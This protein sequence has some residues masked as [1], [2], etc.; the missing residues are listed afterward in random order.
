MVYLLKFTKNKNRNFMGKQ[1]QVTT[2][3]FENIKSL[4]L[5][6]KDFIFLYSGTVRD[7]YSYHKYLIMVVTDR[8]WH[9]G[10]EIANIPF[11]GQ[12][13]N[14]MMV[15]AL[16]KIR[17]AEICP[18]WF[19]KTPQGNVSVGL[20]ATAFE[21]KVHV[22][23]YL[24]G[25]LWDYYKEDKLEELDPFIFSSDMKENER[26]SKAFVLISEQGANGKE[27]FYYSKDVYVAFSKSKYSFAAAFLEKI[28]ENA[29][30]LHNFGY[31]DAMNTKDL[32]MASSTYQFGHYFDE[33]VLIDEAHTPYTATYWE[34]KPYIKDSTPVDVKFKFLTFRHWLEKNHVSAINNNIIDLASADYI[35]LYNRFTG[36][37]FDE[38]NDRI[39]EKKFVELIKSSFSI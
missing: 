14:L 37:E 24:T 20:L 13:L 9:E 32:F 16:K 11:K 7:M 5:A 27:T 18:V 36:L 19:E 38:F 12:V 30:N 3:Y 35:A 2:S 28:I 6:L 39:P 33:V 22:F 15:D 21:F 17:M 1:L 34:I 31:E 26:L 25:P 8:F 10:V 23:G 29:V 4:I